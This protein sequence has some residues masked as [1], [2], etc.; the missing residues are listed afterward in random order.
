MRNA[1]TGWVGPNL[2]RFC[3]SCQPARARYRR[4]GRAAL[5]RERGGLAGKPLFDA[6]RNNTEYFL[7]RILSFNLGTRNPSKAQKQQ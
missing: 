3:Q 2:T 4:R 7:D 6:T 5:Q 1:K